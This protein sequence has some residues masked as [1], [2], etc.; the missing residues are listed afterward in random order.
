MHE[1]SYQYK[2]SN[3]KFLESLDIISLFASC[4]MQ[5]Y[6]KN[7]ILNVLVIMSFTP[8]NWSKK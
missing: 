6:I 3:V 1:L 8:L 2:I 7:D 4:V 5:L